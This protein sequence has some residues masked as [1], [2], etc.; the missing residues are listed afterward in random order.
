MIQTEIH[1]REKLDSNWSDWF[2]DM[3]IWNNSGGETILCGGL[4]DKS[5]VYGVLSRLGILGMTLI[6]LTCCEESNPGPQ[7]T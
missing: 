6:S 5:A 3:H 2:E 7:T 4:R 1:I